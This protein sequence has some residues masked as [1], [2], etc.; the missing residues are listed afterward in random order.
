MVPLRRKLAARWRNWTRANFVD[1]VPPGDA[2]C[3][4]GCRKTQCRLDRWIEC[5]NRLAYVASVASS[6]NASKTPDGTPR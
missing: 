6:A 3:E 5:E 1:E 2:C 4:Y